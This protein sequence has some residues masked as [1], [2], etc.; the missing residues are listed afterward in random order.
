M[1]ACAFATDSAAKSMA[2]VVFADSGGI[3]V[4]AFAVKMSEYCCRCRSLDLYS[5]CTNNLGGDM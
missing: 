4:V 5:T 1:C 3:I 2:L